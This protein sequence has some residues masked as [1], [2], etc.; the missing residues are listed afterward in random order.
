M[1]GDVWIAAESARKTEALVLLSSASVVAIEVIHV[2]VNHLLVCVRIV[3]WLVR[4]WRLH[5]SL[6]ACKVFLVIVTEA[7]HRVLLTSHLIYDFFARPKLLNVP[8]P[9]LPC[10]KTDHESK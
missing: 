1:H 10:C 7:G 2:L 4:V 8:V 6:A 3:P 5:W 9:V